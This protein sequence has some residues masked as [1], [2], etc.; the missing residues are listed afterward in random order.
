MM[1]YGKMFHSPQHCKPAAVNRN[2]FWI[3]RTF[4]SLATQCHRE[5][6]NRGLT[7]TRTQGHSL[8]VRQLSNGAIW[9]TSDIS[10]C[11]NRFVPESARNNG[12]TN[13]TCLFVPRGPSREPTLSHYMLQ[14]SQKSWSNRDSNPKPLTLSS[15]LPT[16]LPSQLVDWH[17]PPA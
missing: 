3:V 2:N 10:P 9:P 16:E 6:K 13:E 1:M 4:V 8:S 17:F 5:G 11:S 7:G 15:I 12:G 14:G